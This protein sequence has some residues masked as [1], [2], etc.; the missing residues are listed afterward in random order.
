M[1]LVILGILLTLQKIFFLNMFSGK[2][3]LVAG[4]ASKQNPPGRA[5]TSP[6]ILQIYETLQFTYLFV[7]GQY[8]WNN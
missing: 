6:N 4:A 3:L 7:S 2:K 1:L 8:G 5:K